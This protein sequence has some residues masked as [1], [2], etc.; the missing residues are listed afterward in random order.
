MDIESLR[1][2]ALAKPDCEEGFPFG[3][4]T[5]VFKVNGKMFMLM[6]MDEHPL[7]FNVK[8]DPDMAVE[9]REQYPESI[10]PAYH[11][12]KKHWN[13]IVVDGHLT[14]KQIHGFIDDSYTLI[15]G[16]KKKRKPIG[17]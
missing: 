17:K 12:N 11:M 3:E 4:S 13:S 6:S 8:C 9:L 2:Y 1:Q 7:R 10:L 15:G 14:L 16:V 5:L